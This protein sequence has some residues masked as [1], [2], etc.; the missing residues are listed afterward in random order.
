MWHLNIPKICHFYWG[1]GKL[2]YLRYLSVYSF[3]KHNPDWTVM[4]WTSNNKSELITW[5]T[6]EQNYTLDCDD[7]FDNLIRLPVLVNVVDFHNDF[8]SDVHKSDILRLSLLHKY[9][10]VWSD[11]D[12]LYVNPVT[13]INVNTPKNNTQNTFV[14]VNKGTHFIGFLMSS[15][16]NQLFKKMEEFAGKVFDPNYYQTIGICL[17]HTCIPVDDFPPNV[18]NINYNNFYNIEWMDVDRLFFEN[19]EISFESNIGIHWFGGNLVSGKFL[20][21][22]NGGRDD[23]PNTNFCNI[24]NS[25]YH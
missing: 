23:L 20:N 13:N 8:I 6:N 19:D 18:A 11:M 9:G 14:C 3:M 17:F 25:F 21:D 2:P 22:T 16:N 4:L 1:G 24:I 10:G 15:H 5:T 7:W 12:I